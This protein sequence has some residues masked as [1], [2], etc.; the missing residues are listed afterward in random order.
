MTLYSGQGRREDGT[1]GSPA[2]DGGVP[3]KANRAKK[4]SIT[5]QPRSARAVVIRLVAPPRQRQIQTSLSNRLRSQ[6]LSI[7]L[8]GFQTAKVSQYPTVTAFSAVS[9]HSPNWWTD[10]C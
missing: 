5:R 7:N 2:K 3:P 6:R 4:L 9:L 10:F 1:A 8:S